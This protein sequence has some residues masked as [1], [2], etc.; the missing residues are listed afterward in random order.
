MTI[1]G[2]DKYMFSINPGGPIRYQ[3]FIEDAIAA[4]EVKPCA[5]TENTKPVA[6]VADEIKKLKE[7]YDSG[8]ITKA[9]YDTQKKKLL[10][11]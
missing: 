9:E 10:N 8:A 11:Q 7:L 5:S 6:S 2:V 3:V 4:C 1:N